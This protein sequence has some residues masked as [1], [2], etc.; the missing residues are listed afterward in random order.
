MPINKYLLIYF[1]GMLMGVADIIPGVSGGTMA[2]ITGIYEELIHSLSVVDKAFIKTLFSKKYSNAF[3][4]VNFK[5]L[6]PLAMGVISSVI[7]FAKIVHQMME[8]YPVW[9]WSLFFSLILASTVLIFR[10]IQSPRCL[11]AVVFF[12]IGLVLAYI[13]VSLIPFETPHTP[14]YLF[15]AGVIAIS[16]M[17]LPGLSGAFLLLVMGK[18]FFVTGALKNPFAW[19]NLKV[20]L[21][22]SSGCFVGLLSFA[23]ILK[24]LLAR[25]YDHTLYFLLGVMLGALKKVWPWQRILREE[26]RNNK[27]YV[28]ETQNYWPLELN[29]E[30]I[31][32]LAVMIIGVII[33]IGIERIARENH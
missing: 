23:K 7:L 31:I 11:R 16:A 17:I 28:L 32:A 19:E 3:K 26:L 6:L 30:V 14:S 20:V 21:I 15:G 25:Y 29:L 33:V 10:K 5:F 27:H 24:V 18:Y 12:P 2:F 22:F 4:Q 1:K 13:L 8:S 9:T